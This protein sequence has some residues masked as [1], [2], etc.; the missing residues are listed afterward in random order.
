MTTEEFLA[1]LAL[2]L[3][4]FIM[5]ALNLKTGDKTVRRLS[6]WALLVMIVLMFAYLMRSLL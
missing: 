6:H 2:A 3:F 5:G 4:T 1:Y